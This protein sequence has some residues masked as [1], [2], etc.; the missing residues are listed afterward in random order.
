[1]IRIKKNNIYSMIKKES[2]M[3]KN[4][5][6]II[7]NIIVYLKDYNACKNCK[8]KEGIFYDNSFCL[9]CFFDFNIKI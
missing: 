5:F 8:F 7:E 2:F 6:N 4:I 3:E 9:S 1:M